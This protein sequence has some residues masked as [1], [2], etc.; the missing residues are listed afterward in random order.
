MPLPEYTH[1]YIHTHYPST[2]ACS[3]LRRYQNPSFS[4]FLLYPSPFLP[5]YPTYPPI[6]LSHHLQKEKKAHYV[7]DNSTPLLS[8]FST[9]LHFLSSSISHIII[10]LILISSLL[11][12]PLFHS[13]SFSPLVLTPFLSIFLLPPVFLY[14]LLCQT[15]L[16]RSAFMRERK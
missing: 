3:Q 9:P 10:L 16:I 8:F 13:I 1:T 6:H 15:S 14:I 5:T 11:F 4:L 2:R 7:I 12:H